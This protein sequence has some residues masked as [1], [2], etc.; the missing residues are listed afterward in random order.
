MANLSN[1]SDRIKN[2]Q[3]DLLEFLPSWEKQNR[4]DSELYYY[5]RELG[6]MNQLLENIK[7]TDSKN[8]GQYKDMNDILVDLE[9]AFE[10][11]KQYR[12]Q[13][14]KEDPKNLDT[15]CSEGHYENNMRLLKK[16]QQY[17][18]TLLDRIKALVND[19]LAEKGITSVK[20]HDYRD[21]YKSMKSCSDISTEEEQPGSKPNNRPTN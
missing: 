3:N 9:K 5:S 10:E 2:L 6:Q 15:F 21:A 13:E 7:A 18:P 4:S 16:F 19:Y 8:E 17:I 14:Q 1:I 12:I 11:W 20:F